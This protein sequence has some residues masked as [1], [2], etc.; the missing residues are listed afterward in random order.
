MLCVYMHTIDKFCLKGNTDFSLSYMYNIA[1]LI[2]HA[3]L[4]RFF[5]AEVWKFRF[6]ILTSQPPSLPPP[7]LLSYSFESY[8]FSNAAEL[9]SCIALLVDFFSLFRFSPISHTMG[10]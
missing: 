9:N 7:P 1:L 4:C 10:A 8:Y 2:S 3:T 6:G 5:V